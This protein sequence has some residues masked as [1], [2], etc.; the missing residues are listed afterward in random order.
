MSNPDPQ[1]LNPDNRSF[2]AGSNMSI[3]AHFLFR[4]ICHRCHRSPYTEF[5]G[6]DEDWKGARTFTEEILIQ[7]NFF[8]L[9]H[10]RHLSRKSPN[11]IVDTRRLNR[12]LA[13]SGCYPSLISEPSKVPPKRTMVLRGD[14]L[15]GRDW[16][17]PPESK[18]LH[19]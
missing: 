9:P 4:E 8:D 17:I 15:N 18:G 6:R 13:E 1:T 12:N 7:A 2:E 11:Q 10:G 5:I 3:K 19:K 16:V 14:G